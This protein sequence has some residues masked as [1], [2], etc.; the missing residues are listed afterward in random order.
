MSFLYV[1]I[2]PLSFFLAF[3]IL[4]HTYLVLIVCLL[5][6]YKIPDS[7]NCI[8]TFFTPHF[9]NVKFVS[10]YACY[11]SCLELL[12]S[13]LLGNFF[14]Y[15]LISFMLSCSVKPFLT[16]SL[17]AVNWMI[18][19]SVLILYFSLKSNFQNDKIMAHLEI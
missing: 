8:L 10:H 11:F 13:C 18:W 4:T 7:K 17:T 5:L 6:T 3:I 9:V 15:P 2:A 16:S 1:V 14:L 19:S 12:S